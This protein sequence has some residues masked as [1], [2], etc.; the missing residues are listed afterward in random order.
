MALAGQ[1]KTKGMVAQL[2]IAST[3]NQSMAAII[4]NARLAPR[5]LFW[6]LDCNYENIRNLAGGDLRDGL[7]L[8]LIGSIRC[9]LPSMS[10]QDIIA[11]FLDRETAKIDELIE[12]KQQLIELLREK[13]RVA[14]HRA[15]TK[16]L[17]FTTPMKPSGIDWLGDVPCH[18]QLKR[19]KFAVTFQRGHDLPASERVEGD[20][21]VV[22]SAGPSSYHDKAAARGPGIVTGRY[23][24]I[25]TFYLVDGDYWP[26]NTTLYSI[27]LHG[28]QPRFLWYMLHILSDVF[29]VNS[30]KSAVPGVD[31]NDLHEVLI[32]IPPN[33]EQSEI[34]RHLD[35]ELHGFEQLSSHVDA[36]LNRLREY[37][38]T[39]ISAAVTGQIDVR[40]DRE[41]A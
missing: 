34:S 2:A 27:D 29:V 41:E 26:L 15:V 10:E 22:S 21:P 14:V 1:G 4:P 25:G 9:P 24:T 32:A 3:C 36:A 23:G 30:A 5:F 39:L 12:K 17:D 35:G 6:W 7:N 40:H 8:E 20:V 11:A 33:D 37:R 18:W 38:S 28:N 13:C 19:L 31:R 16:G